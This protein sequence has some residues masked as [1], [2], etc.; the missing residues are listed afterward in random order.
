MIENHPEHPATAEPGLRYLPDDLDGNAQ[1]LVLWNRNLESHGDEL[2]V[3]K[4]AE[5]F[6]FGKD[7][8]EADQLIHRIAQ[9]EPN[10][11][12]WPGEL[13]ELYRMSGIPGRYI[14]DPAARAI[15]S[16]RR[17]LE[18]T[19]NVTARESLAGDMAQA[20]FKVGDLA[21][22]AELAKIHLRS[23]DR[24]ALQRSN[25]IL[26]RVALRSGDV[27][28]AKQY[29]LDSSS[30]LAEK[31]VS[32]SGPTLVLAKELLQQGERDTVLQYLDN[33]LS[34]WPRGEGVLQLWIADIKNGRTPNFG[35]LAN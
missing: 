21:G 5:K 14:E 31:D 17:V 3:L 8:E 33:C 20:L 16:Y 35:N 24:T 34:L 25:T 30:P 19:H 26:G 12:Q 22:A 11:K 27:G 7:P 1:I 13:A 9:K 32:I 10:D 28:G 29:L 15:E 6:F 2:A 4:D 18:L 23:K